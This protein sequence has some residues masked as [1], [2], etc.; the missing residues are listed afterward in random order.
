MKEQESAKVRS[1]IKPMIEIFQKQLL[2][3]LLQSFSLNNQDDLQKALV[4]IIIRFYNQRQEFLTHAKNML[5]LFDK[6][7]IKTFK[8]CQK[9]AQLL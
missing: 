3:S 5:L 8:T 7:N 6:D 1:K 2:P 9:K 4:D